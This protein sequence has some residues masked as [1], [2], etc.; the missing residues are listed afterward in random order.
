METK[1][2]CMLLIPIVVLVILMACSKKELN[3]TVTENEGIKT[4]HNKNIPSDPNFKITPKEV[5][6]IHGYDENAQDTLRNFIH[7]QDIA[8]D[9]SGNIY[10]LDSRLSSIKKFDS[11]SKFVKSIGRKG[12]GP[13]EMQTSWQLML[14]NDSLYVVDVTDSRFSIFN[15]SG[16]FIRSFLLEDGASLVGMIPLDQSSFIATAQ[17]WKVKDEEPYYVNNLNI[18]DT[19]FKVI[20]GLKER[21]G[22]YVGKNMNWDDY[23]SSYCVGKKNIYLAKNSFDEYSIDVLD[24]KGNLLYTIKKDYRKIKMPHESAESFAESRKSTYMDGTKREFDIKYKRVIDDMGMF[25]TKD[26]YLLVKTPVE[27]DEKNE[28]DYIVDAFKDGVFINRFRMDIGK[29]FDFFNSDHKR[30]MIGNRIYH[31]NREDNCVTIYEY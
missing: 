29:S 24:L 15:S 3:Y 27:R 18:F 26:G 9:E 20:K 31:Q 4:Y 2:S 13:G 1:E 21:I 12:T 30:W 8:I 6:T 16:E 17:T 19:N 25:E 28:F 5:F 14:F 22:K 10:V 11:D 7:P 23:T